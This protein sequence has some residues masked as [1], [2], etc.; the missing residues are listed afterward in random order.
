MFSWDHEATLRGHKDSI[1]VIKLEK[2]LLFSGSDDKTVKI[3]VYLLLWLFI[4][5]EL[6]QKYEIFSLDA[7][8]G[9]VMDLLIIEETGHLVTCS[10]DETI[11]IWN[12]PIREKRKEIS[13]PGN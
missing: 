7:H 4:I 2:N 12:Y 11:I 1:N 8:K 3:W 10:T 9:S 5:K 13:R 6:T